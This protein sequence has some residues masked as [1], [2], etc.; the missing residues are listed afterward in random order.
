M[1][2]KIY[3]IW[4]IGV[5]LLQQ[6]AF[7]QL[8][9]PLLGIQHFS[10][11]EGTYESEDY[12]VFD[13]LQSKSEIFNIFMNYGHALGERK[14][15]FYNLS[16]QDFGMTMNASDLQNNVIFKSIPANHY[17]I[18]K[19]SAIGASVGLNAS[20]SGNWN[21]MNTVQLSYTNDFSTSLL[22]P[23]FYYG[24]FTHIEKRGER[25]NYGF[26]LYLNQLQGR[27]FYSPVLSLRVKNDV[28]GLELLFPEKL[29]LWQSTWKNGYFQ[30][31][32]ELNSYSLLFKSSSSSSTSNNIF[33]IKSAL[34]YHHI[35]EKNLD[36]SMALGLPVW[37]YSIEDNKEH[38]QYSQTNGLSLQIGISLIINDER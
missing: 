14:E 18:P 32:G 31:E 38:Y 8:G 16:Y 22:I 20:L 24:L 12:P 21:W 7:C 34:A 3:L 2:H 29:R 37:F 5:S 6:K 25:V 36:I 13:K 30:L 33:L 1:T 27:L 15:M 28:R 9:T 23:K 26:G 11:S 10:T 17:S 35:V 4:L 19:F